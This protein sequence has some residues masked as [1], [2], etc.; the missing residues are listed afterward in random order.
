V[1]K[2]ADPT[3]TG[4]TFAG[5]YSDEA[6]T[7][8]VSWPYIMTAS[9]V[10]FYAKWTIN[11]YTVSFDSNEGSAVTAITQD[12]NT[13]VTKPSDPT[14]T[15]YTFAGWYSDEALTS[16]V[17]WPYTMT[18]E[19]VTFYAKWTV[20]QYTITLNS[21]GGGTVNQ[22][23]QN[24]KSSV[25]KPVDPFRLGYTF[26]GWYSDSVLTSPVTWPYIMT[27]S[28]VTF[29]G[30]WTINQYTI[31]FNSNGGSN[32]NSITQDYGSSVTK[33]ADPMKTGYKFIGWY[34]DNGLTRAVTWPYAMTFSSVTFYAKWSTEQNTVA[35]NSNGGSSVSPVTVAYGASISKPAD[36]VMAG[37]T[38]AGWYLDSG[39]TSA[40]IWPYTI[41]ASNVTFYAKWTVNQYT[42]SF[43]S[44][45]GSS[46]AV[47]T[48]NYN[49]SVTKP[50]DPTKSGYKFAGWFSDSGLINAVTWPYTITTSN[51]TFYAKWMV[52]QY[53]LSFDTNGGSSV[54]AITQDAD[55]EA[56]IS[57]TSEKAGYSFAG[58]NTKA[59]GTGTDYANGGKIKLT[60]NITLY[61]IWNEDIN[62]PAVESG[63]TYTAQVSRDDSSVKGNVI[64]NL[65]GVEV[66]APADV[67]KNIIS[68]DESSS[69]RITQTP[70]DN[71]TLDELMSSLG[72]GN[73]VVAG[74]D[75]S[76]EKIFANGNVEQIHELSGSIRIVISLSA[77]QLSV[78]TDPTTAKLYWYNPETGELT[79]MNA[80]FDLAAGTA[81]FYTDHFSTFLVANI[82][83]A[84]SI[85]INGSTDTLEDTASNNITIIIILSVT[86]STVLL[87]AILILIFRRKNKK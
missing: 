37:Y 39:C 50:Q 35:F 15:G 83:N 18:A 84:D 27:A 61:A 58:W 57:G 87:L 45:G 85:E 41:A 14:K 26:A 43:N 19:N 36:P 31:T 65:G 42:V 47:V 51:V 79:D 86:A 66:F 60:G 17:S 25:S 5:W 70:T 32:V 48:Q 55:T 38:F 24:Y 72:E 63:G 4:Y 76:L 62:I 8:A 12:Y 1:T 30:K 46:A 16:S 44:N 34:T 81:T 40:V 49:T 77:E 21:N 74:F 22:I 9:D 2:P 6:L 64:S 75:I 13:S 23:I 54:G 67:Y 11:Q 68:S 59:D 69:L 3:K 7:N 53:T 56:V 29:Y 80:T 82:K 20:N 33:P 73:T 28:N 52:S 78:V 10:T 71:D